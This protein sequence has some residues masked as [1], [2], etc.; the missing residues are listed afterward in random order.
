L[1]FVL[2]VQ[3][4]IHTKQEKN[5]QNQKQHTDVKPTTAVSRF[6]YIA[7]MIMFM[8]CDDD[9]CVHKTTCKQDKNK[10]PATRV[11][12]ICYCCAVHNIL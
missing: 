10:K 11:V 9:A 6:G 1:R 3:I 4:P 2:E 5:I 8:Q 12:S 7:T